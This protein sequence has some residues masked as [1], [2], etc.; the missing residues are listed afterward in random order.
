MYHA[1]HCE[2]IFLSLQPLKL[3]LFPFQRTYTVPILLIAMDCICSV[4]LLG[5]AIHHVS[6]A[7]VKE[8]VVS[9]GRGSPPTSYN[10]EI[11]SVEIKENGHWEGSEEDMIYK[12][13]GRESRKNQIKE[14]IKVQGACSEFCFKMWE[15]YRVSLKNW[16][17]R[18]VY[19]WLCVCI[20]IYI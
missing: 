18:M 10:L 16:V 12:I 9:R 5:L 8:G 3:D 11:T 15:Q 6:M 20:C 17:S 19:L 7:T 1:C 2:Y 13:P 14:E 4:V